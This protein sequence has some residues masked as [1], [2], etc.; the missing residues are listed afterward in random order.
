MIKDKLNFAIVGFGRIGRRHAEHILRGA[1]LLAV[2]DIDVKT[3]SEV[4][5][6]PGSP[7]FFNDLNKMISSLPNLDIVS[8]CTPNSL[9]AP[10][11]ILSL[12]HGL[13]VL[14]EKP[15]ALSSFDCGEMIKAAERN[16]RRLFVVKQNRFNPPVAALK[17]VI[18]EG[19]LGAI[20]SI[21]LNCFWNRDFNYYANSWK[22]TL[23][24][25]GGTLFTQFSHFVDLLYWLFGDVVYVSSLCENYGHKGIIEFEDTGV[26]ILKFRSGVLGT[27]NYN[28]NSYNHNMEGSIVVFGEKG[29]VKVGG[30]Y[31]NELEY[32]QIDGYKISNL[33]PGNKPN[34]YGTYVGSMS[35]HDLIY[36]NIYDVFTK[37][38]SVATNM[39]EGLKTVEIIEKIYKSSKSES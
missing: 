10:Q 38:F 1:N 25:D 8:I 7:K 15:M 39:Y 33:A 16:N 37:N 27:I 30:Q 5:A 2:C 9:H 26:A 23:E 22:G 21:Q 32:Q 14:C 18:D 11:S 20:Y 29:T 12:N 4:K 19:R 6:L 28:V 3:E 17:K 31:L 34:N 35:N 13:H 24:F 36:Q